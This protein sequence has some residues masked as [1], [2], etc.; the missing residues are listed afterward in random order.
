VLPWRRGKKFP[1][2][3]LAAWTFWILFSVGGLLGSK[4]ELGLGDYELAQLCFKLGISLVGVPMLAFRTIIRDKYP[5]FVKLSVLVIAVGAAFAVVQFM[6]PNQFE[7]F[8]HEKGRGGGFW[9]SPNNC[10]EICVFGLFFTMVTPFKSKTFTNLLRLILV[11]GLMASLSRGGLVMLFVGAVSYAVAAKQWKTLAR[12][13]IGFLIIMALGIGLS[14]VAKSTGSA[15]SKR[16]DRWMEVLSG[17]V[18][19]GDRMFLWSHG[20]AA[21]MEDPILGR[22]HR[23]MERVVPIGSGAGPHNY[24]IYVW[25]NSGF[26]GLLGFLMFVASLLRMGLKCKQIQNRAALCAMAGMIATTAMVSHSF[27]N[28]VYFGPIFAMMALTAY[29]DQTAPKPMFVPPQ[30]QRQ[31]QFRPRMA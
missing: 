6:L 27:I 24:Y 4:R 23:S 2:Y 12:V 1:A 31:P 30:P 18:S 15:S 3:F 8:M 11:G 5:M 13:G 25:G 7:M 22:G 26:M 17:N 16:I 10:A 19:G 21:V 14:V 29:Y 28:T 9:V 20:M